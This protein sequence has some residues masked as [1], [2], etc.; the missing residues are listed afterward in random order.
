MKELQ[1]L[2]DALPY[3]LLFVLPLFIALSPYNPVCDASEL[4]FPIHRLAQFE[5]S[6]NRFGSKTAAIS[7][8]ARSANAASSNL[9]RKIVIAKLSGKE[10]LPI[11]ANPS[12]LSQVVFKEIRPSPILSLSCSAFG[13]L[14]QSLKVG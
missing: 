1:D 6:G 14:Y 2:I 12:C 13:V 3:W 9:L 7:I 11:E 10:Q 4:H 5:I 8:E